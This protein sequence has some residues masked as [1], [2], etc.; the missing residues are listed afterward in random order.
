MVNPLWARCVYG[1]GVSHDSML[2]FF[3]QQAETTTRIAV[4]AVG[5]MRKDLHV[6]QRA[7]KG[8]SDRHTIEYVG[9]EGRIADSTVTQTWPGQHSAMFQ[10]G[11]NLWPPSDCSLLF[12]FI[13]SR[14]CVGL[15]NTTQKCCIRFCNY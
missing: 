13:V 12:V 7:S 8:T 3:K 1:V 4:K 11:V 5:L 9:R 6:N 14:H 15:A 2:H 10:H